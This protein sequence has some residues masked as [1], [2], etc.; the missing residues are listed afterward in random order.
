MAVTREALVI[1]DVMSHWPSDRLRL[2]S[3]MFDTINY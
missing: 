3:G 1:N 2:V